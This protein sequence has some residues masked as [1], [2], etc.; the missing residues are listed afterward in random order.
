MIL[1][2]LYLT[3]L[4]T[5]K[6]KV[7]PWYSNGVLTSPNINL[8]WTYTPIFWL[9]GLSLMVYMTTFWIVLSRPAMLTLLSPLLK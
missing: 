6:K 8:P 9:G 5:E 3:L 1:I 4:G 2:G 7:D